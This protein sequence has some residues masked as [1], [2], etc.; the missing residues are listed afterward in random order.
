MSALSPGGERRLLQSFVAVAA[1]VP[2]LSGL[3]GVML[4]LDTFGAH[5]RLSLTGDS[6]VRY[7]SGLILAIGLAYW[8]AVPRIE[9]QGAKF[10]LLTSLVLIGGCARL[11]GLAH[12][13]A[14]TRGVIGALAMELIVTPSL[15]LWRERLERRLRQAQITSSVLSSVSP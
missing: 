8:S 10:R 2:V 15:A 7:L 9:M 3:W 1:L 13:G 5:A 11:I 6:H 4:G 12:F 14:P